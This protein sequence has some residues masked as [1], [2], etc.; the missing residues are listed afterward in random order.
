MKIVFCSP[1]KLQLMPGVTIESLKE[2]TEPFGFAIL[3]DTLAIVQNDKPL[4]KFT[5]GHLHYTFF[6]HKMIL[7]NNKSEKGKS[8]IFELEVSE[9]SQQLKLKKLIK[10][11]NKLSM[12]K[13]PLRTYTAVAVRESILASTQQPST[14]LRGFV[15]LLIV[16]SII[17]YSRSIMEHFIT[18]GPLFINY[19]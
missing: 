10:R 2:L 17:S 7:S 8:I 19:V 12:Y 14:N 9:E 3:G 4:A 15:N 11:H 16:Y 6:A 5:K 18:N 1:E 13:D